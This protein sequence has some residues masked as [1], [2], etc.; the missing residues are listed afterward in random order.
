MGA[1]DVEAV[2]IVKTEFNRI[3]KYAVSGNDIWSSA[4]GYSDITYYF[5]CVCEGMGV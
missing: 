5:L 2:H 1:R 3:L 4:R